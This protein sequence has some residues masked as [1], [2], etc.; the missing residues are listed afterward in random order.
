MM[1]RR[2]LTDEHVREILKQ[3]GVVPD[4]LW[5]VSQRRERM[6]WMVNS[7]EDRWILKKE[8][9][10]FEKM[11]FIAGAHQHL[12]D[13]G[14]PI[15]KLARTSE[16][17]LCVDG[18][19]AGGS[20]VMYERHT[21][22]PLNYY[23]PDHLQKAMAFKAAFHEKSAGYEKPEGAKRRRRLGKWEKLYRWKIQQ[24]QGF[25]TIARHFG[26]DPFS[27]LFMQHAEEMI[28]RGKAAFE[29]LDAPYFQE[30]TE[31]FVESGMFCEQD[32][33]LARLTMKDGRAFMKELRSVNRDMPTRDIRVMLDKVMKKF[34]VWDR[35]LCVQML[36]AYDKVR[37]LDK[38]EFR[39]LRTDLQFP[40][41]FASIAQNYYLRE[42][43]AWNDDKFL[44]ALQNVIAVEQS[45][46][47]I[48]NDFEEIYENVKTHDSTAVR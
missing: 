11:L 17:D 8:P 43:K 6:Q 20:F 31:K 39:V 34:S 48:L 5:L 45:K 42:K 15:A 14:L 21:G 35:E 19:E 10:A 18:K 38:D 29:A 37:P 26:N 16:G 22:D 9:R 23:D 25:Q 24:L 41:L 33:T 40:H 28:K 32:F 1:E 47:A 2:S 30:Q 46:T 36:R 13:N 7:G 44:L 4:T 27:R 12:H 3:Y